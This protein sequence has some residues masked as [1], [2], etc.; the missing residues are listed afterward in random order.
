MNISFRHWKIEPQPWAER[1]INA[2]AEG[3]LPMAT[4]DIA[5]H[6]AHY[7]NG[8]TADRYESRNDAL[9]SI[10]WRRESGLKEIMV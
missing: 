1:A 3:G 9:R 10:A 2:R 5:S 4:G 7:I 8:A 6:L